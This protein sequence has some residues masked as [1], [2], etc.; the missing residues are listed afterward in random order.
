MLH[1]MSLGP[2]INVRMKNVVTRLS[3]IMNIAELFITGSDQFLSALP[4]LQ[5][6]KKWN[7]AFVF[8]WLVETGF[9]K[10]WKF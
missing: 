1:P 4:G 6:A 8:N 5:N 10:K 2:E 3:P 9:T 7:N